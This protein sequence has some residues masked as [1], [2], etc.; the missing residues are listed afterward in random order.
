ML[1]VAAGAGRNALYLTERGFTVHAIDYNP[2][3]LMELQI[4]ARE[5]PLSL[6]T[7]EVV[8]LEGEPFLQ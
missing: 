8:D 3:A 5:E 2:E 6:V 7:I 1:D 4:T